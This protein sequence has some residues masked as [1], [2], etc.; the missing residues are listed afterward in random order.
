MV[1][2]ELRLKPISR[3][4]LWARHD[5]GIGDDHIER[6]AGGKQ[7][8]R[9]APHALKRRQIELHELQR[10]SAGG[11]GANLLRSRVCLREIT[12]GSYDLR[13]VRRQGA[14]RLDPQA[15]RDTGDEHAPSS[16]VD[17]SQDLVRRRC[18]SE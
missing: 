16:Q 5:A 17:A 6:F 13:P 2:A 18:G 1:G 14:R 7:T 4:A 10:A 8:V 3:G 12:R 9:A 15:R 11:L